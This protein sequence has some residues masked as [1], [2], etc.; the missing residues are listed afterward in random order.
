MIFNI[1]EEIERIAKTEFED[2]IVSINS[3]G[4]KARLPNKL[5]IFFYDDSFLD[6]WLSIDGDYSYHWERR[7]QRGE[8][9]RWDNAPDHPEISTFPK[10]FHDGSQKNIIASD[11]SGDY[12]VAIREILQFIRSVL[13]KKN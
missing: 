8:I 1:Y 7:A 13:L 2:I 11:L 10:H 4:G 9:Y 5:R 3:I 6:I 12:C